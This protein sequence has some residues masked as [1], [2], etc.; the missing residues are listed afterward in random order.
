MELSDKD[1]ERILATKE[2]IRNL[3]SEI[4]I[5][6][7]DSENNRDKIIE[8][9]SHIISYISELSALSNYL[10]CDPGLNVFRGDLWDIQMLFESDGMKYVLRNDIERFCSRANS[11]T[12]HEKDM[13]ILS[14]I[15]IK[16][17]NLNII[18]K[19]FSK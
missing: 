17:K 10:I 6:L 4:S 19:P 5:L 8:K 18:N 13:S 12:F 7:V 15:Q 16:L 3:T 11:V 2:N 1:K 14:K 9:M